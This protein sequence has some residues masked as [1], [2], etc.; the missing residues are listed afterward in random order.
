[1]LPPKDGTSM[2]TF[3]R[4][5]VKTGDRPPRHQAHSRGSMIP[6]YRNRALKRKFGSMFLTHAD[7]TETPEL[8]MGKKAKHKPC[9]TQD[10]TESKE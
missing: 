9:R 3:P 5:D 1:M 8:Q 10:R 2:K 7:P 6:I 4:R